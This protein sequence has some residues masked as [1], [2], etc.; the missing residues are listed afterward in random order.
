VQKPDV[1]LVQIDLLSLSRIG[2]GP[3][4]LNFLVIVH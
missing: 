2:L 4:A 1:Y 3:A